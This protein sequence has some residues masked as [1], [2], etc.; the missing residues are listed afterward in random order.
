MTVLPWALE[1]CLN[2]KSVIFFLLLS[3]II[4]FPSS[5]K[6]LV[7]RKYIDFN[8]HTLLFFSLWTFSPVQQAYPRCRMVEFDTKK[9]QYWYSF[10]F[11]ESKIACKLLLSLMN[12]VWFGLV[13]RHINLCRLSNAKS[14]F[15]YINNSTS[16][17]SLQYKKIFFCLHTVKCHYCSILNNSVWLKYT[18]SMAKN[19]SIL[20]NSV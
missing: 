15:S 16:K 19:K 18:V 7:S 5:L 12:L 11:F 20:N 17:T 6:L 13:L 9:V 8:I 2:R 4:Y 10:P 1:S 14:I 3:G